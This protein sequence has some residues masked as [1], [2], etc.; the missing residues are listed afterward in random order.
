M[1]K[2]LLS[3]GSNTN[4]LFNLNRAIKILQ[5][6]FK[7]IKFT[8]SAESKPYGTIYKC[9]FL[10]TLAYFETNISKDELV[11]CLKSI[12]TE[13]GRRPEQKA[14]GKIIIDIDLIK[15][16][17]EIVKPEDFKRSYVRNL[18]EFVPK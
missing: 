5:L 14:Q 15:W 7:N 17:N 13:M 1:N 9:V 16:N 11:L 12:E 2:A 18:L 6:Y 3:I 10:N 4:A 8:E